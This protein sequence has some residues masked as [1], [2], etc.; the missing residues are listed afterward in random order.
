[1]DTIFTRS[2]DFSRYVLLPSHIERN[3]YKLIEIVEVVEHCIG[4]EFDEDIKSFEQEVR[5]LFITWCCN[6]YKPV[7]LFWTNSC[8]LLSYKI[9]LDTRSASFIF[10]A[11][12]AIFITSRIFALSELFCH[13][14][15]TIAL[16]KSTSSRCSLSTS[17]FIATFL[18]CS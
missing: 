3:Y 11:S 10:L 12:L 13:T 2:R 9:V 18:N 5:P 17:T 7:N 14:L 15:F 4:R 1:M 6:R 16:A 8:K